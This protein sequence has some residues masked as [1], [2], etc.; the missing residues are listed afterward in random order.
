M[1]HAIKQG[2]R[3]A[4][5]AAVAVGVHAAD[6]EIRVI[7]DIPCVE[8][9][10]GPS[11]ADR[12]WFLGFVSGL[13]WGRSSPMPT[14]AMFRHNALKRLPSVNYALEYAN[15]HCKERR[16]ADVSGAALKLQLEL[17]NL[18]R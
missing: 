16:S 17:Q 7:G 11:A 15:T 10:R 6:D 1:R 4:V 13:N 8:W 5:L 3:A 14:D 12:A 9:N 18:Q 2:I